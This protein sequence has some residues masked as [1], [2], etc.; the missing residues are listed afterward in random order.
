MFDT[1]STGYTLDGGHIQRQTQWLQKMI[2]M[3][4]SQ[5]LGD[6]NIKNYLVIAHIDGKT[7]LQSVF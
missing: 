5:T 2:R 3:H 1:D 6:W 4:R 7:R